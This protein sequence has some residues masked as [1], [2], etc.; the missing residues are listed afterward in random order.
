MRRWNDFE[1]GDSSLNSNRSEIATRKPGRDCLAFG[2]RCTTT[3]PSANGLNDFFV[4][5]WCDGNGGVDAE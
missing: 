2:K 1:L 4:F 5:G 3:S